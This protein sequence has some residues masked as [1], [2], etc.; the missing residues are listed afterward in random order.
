MT[1]KQY[2]AAIE[3]I[4]LSQEA[5]GVFFGVSKR[6]GQRWASGE[7]PIPNSVAYALKLMADTGTKPGDLNKNFTNT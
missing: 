7:A 6:Q 5:A 2:R 1:P 4:G 3:A